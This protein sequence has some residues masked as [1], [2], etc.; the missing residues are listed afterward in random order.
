MSLPSAASASKT[1]G[2]IDIDALSLEGVSKTLSS[3]E[4][5][6]LEALEKRRRDIDR[7]LSIVKEQLQQAM[8]TEIFNE[9][10][11]VGETKYGLPLGFINIHLMALEDIGPIKDDD[12][13]VVISVRST[14]NDPT[15]PGPPPKHSNPARHGK[16]K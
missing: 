14:K 13:I 1:V 4:S 11:G 6:K 2:D 9:K 7:E 8:Q 12:C 10:T 15:P 5:S 16:S 3:E